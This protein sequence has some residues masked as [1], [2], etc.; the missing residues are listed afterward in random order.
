M[1][2]TPR[3]L[4]KY[5]PG[6]L[7][8]ICALA[9]VAPGAASGASICGNAF[10]EPPEDCDPPGSITLPSRIAVGRPSWSATST[11]RVRR[12]RPPRT[13]IEH[14]RTT[15]T[16]VDDHDHARPVTRRRPTIAPCGV[17]LDACLDDLTCYKVRGQPG[18]AGL[19]RRPPG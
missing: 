14:G 4:A 3:R 16:T 11:A 17:D 5:L 7:A 6:I 13:T 1:N 12:C 19:P 9:L 2:G 8:L 10:L 15:S 18:D